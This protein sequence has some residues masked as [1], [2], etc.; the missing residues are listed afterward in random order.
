MP[1]STTPIP[2]PPDPSGSFSVAYGAP[3]SKVAR[4]SILSPEEWEQVVQEWASAALK[5]IHGYSEVHRAGGAGDKG[6]DVIAYLGDPSG[7][8][9]NFQCKHYDHS[10]YPGDVW[11]EI[12]KLCYW[13]FMGEFSMPRRYRFVAPKGVGTTLLR[14]LEQPDELKSEF[15]AEWDKKCAEKIVGGKKLELTGDLRAHVDAMDFSI[16]GAVSPVTLLEEHARTIFHPPRFGGGLPPRHD[17]D[18]PP[19]AIEP[20][21]SRYIR[22]LL[23]VY[24]EKVGRDLT[25]PDDLSSCDES[26]T[27]HLRDSR[28]EFFSAECLDKFTRDNLGSTCFE[29]LQEDIEDG[30]REVVEDDYESGLKRVKATISYAKTIP[31]DGHPL[32][33]SVRPRHKAGICHQLANRDRITWIRRA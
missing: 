25:C 16:I 20:K 27:K 22:Q 2:V 23:D 12:G 11:L 32:H 19:D 30:I 4:L 33:G 28:E 17:P 9:D 29:Q 6:R 5:P 8:Y 3:V 24:G 21:E 7:D 1:S 13:T 10:L 15:I 14:L 26:Y 18:G 31:V